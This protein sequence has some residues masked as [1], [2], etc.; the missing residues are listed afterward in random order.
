MSFRK[1]LLLFLV[2][3]LAAAGLGALLS[4]WLISSGLRFWLSRTAQ[5]EGLAVEIGQIDAPFLGD[6]TIAELRVRSA[7]TAA[8]QVHLQASKISLDLNFR[9]RIF[10]REERLLRRVAVARI[11]GNI[12]REAGPAAVRLEWRKL[13]RMLPENFD[14]QNV[15]LDVVTRST[16]FRFRGVELS[17]SEIESGKFSAQ[18]ISVSSPV[19]RQ[20]FTNLRGATAWSGNRLSIAGVSLVRGLDLE[21]LTIDL[22][23][24]KQRRIDLDFYLDA[25]GGT[26]RAS[27]GGTGG[28]R[29]FL[30]D[31]AGSAV[32]VSLSQLA[33]AAGFLEPLSGSVRAAKFTF[34]GNPGEFLD[35]TASVWIEAKDFAWR[36]R[37]ADNVV[38]GATYYDR[39]LQ[40][41]QL[42]LQQQHNELTING[43]LR[44]PQKRS[45]W[46]TL[47]FRGQ[48]NATIPNADSFAQL[49]G[50]R[51]GD[52]SGALFA[53]G[54]IDSLAPTASG[55]LKLRGAGVSFRGVALDSLGAEL[56]LEGSEVTLGNVEFRHGN[57]F[58]RGHGTA[59]LTSPH[60]YSARLTGAVDDLAEYAPL[61]PAKWRAASIGGGM[62]FDWS[63]D[64]TFAAHSGTVQFFARGLQL[65]VAPLRSPLDVTLEG[66]YSPQ[67]IFF[68]TFKLANSRLSLGGFVMLGPDFIELQA[69]ELLLDGVPRARGTLFLPIGVD[70]WRKTGSL[71]EAFDER[72]K[73]DVDWQVDHLA[74]EKLSRALGEE[75][76]TS[77]LLTGKLAV[78]GPLASLQVTTDW[79]LKNLGPAPA[80][81]DLDFN[82]HYALG[83]AE[84]NLR[85]T[86]GVSSPVL[87]RA[88]LPLQLR[89]DA[90][91][92]ASLIEPGQPLS[93]EMDCPAL[94]LETLPQRWQL[95]G[96]KSGLLN[97]QIRLGKTAADPKIQGGTELF[98][99]KIDLG[100][101]FPLLT[102][103]TA[104]ARFSRREMAIEFL[105]FE[106]MGKLFRWQGSL[107]SKSSSVSF[108]LKPWHQV[109][110]LASAPPAVED[111]SPVEEMV[112][113]GTINSPVWSVTFETGAG[114]T[115]R[116]FNPASVPA[117]SP[118][119]LQGEMPESDKNFLDL[120]QQQPFP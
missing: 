27:F 14:L 93:L 111:A 95:L 112:V 106:A 53:T 107:T 117:G 98:D 21:S 102:N 42:Y 10:S 78:Y 9:G 113:K 75:A 34:R 80:P 109:I 61:L 18:Q 1:R 58:L 12:Q 22:S 115:T 83:R 99:G 89:K 68:R 100:P 16:A 62:T 72:Q 48:L 25:F 41:E 74:L 103:V 8:R 60:A 23:S 32:N 77:G 40:V 97:A 56:H 7:R 20:T 36:T 43:E 85:A 17:A 79:Q 30:V 90:P 84:A 71:R 76:H 110:R 29:K 120:R 2:I 5:A 24:L 11:T 94:L 28:A 63:G 65:P 91:S 3:L 13:E 108:D 31:L 37:R 39:R 4:P 49:F 45:G 87:A 118:F 6:V 44:W 67:D 26:V 88:S 114:Q 57:D 51:S 116:F 70:R 101:S 92:F 119:L 69:L 33:Q 55:Q 38:F 81:N 46:S 64:G 73:F 50:A 105:Q 66:S 47:P 96:L 35:A 19:L 86:F 54:Q 15:D 52:F 82:L 59:D 104:E